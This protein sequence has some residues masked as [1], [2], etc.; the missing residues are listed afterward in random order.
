MGEITFI[1]LGI[2]FTS[3]SSSKS[4]AKQAAKT[5]SQNFLLSEKC[6]GEKGACF[7]PAFSPRAWSSS[8]AAFLGLRL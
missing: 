5:A 1:F 2:G 7:P 6:S 4:W 3:S 8:P